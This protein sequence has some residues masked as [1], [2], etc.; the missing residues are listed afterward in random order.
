MK[1]TQKSTFPLLICV[2]SMHLSMSSCKPVFK[3]SIVQ[4]N[5]IQLLN[6]SMLHFSFSGNNSS[7]V[8]ESPLSTQHSFRWHPAACWRLCSETV[9]VQTYLSMRLYLPLLHA[10]IFQASSS[11]YGTC[12]SSICSPFFLHYTISCTP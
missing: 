7:Y 8:G 5:F 2:A 11:S 9:V 10:A 6:S 3:I 1:V 12:F 4:S